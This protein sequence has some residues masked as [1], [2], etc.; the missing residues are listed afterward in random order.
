MN[1]LP[2]TDP[3]RDVVASV[4]LVPVPAPSD[5]DVTAPPVD[6]LPRPDLALVG[7]RAT[8]GEEGSLVAEYGLLAVVAATIAGVLITWARGDVLTS[9]FTQLLNQ[10]RQLV[11]S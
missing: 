2:T 3:D 4:A 9:F 8:T 7:A 10:A 5:Q 6:D 1:H 11:V